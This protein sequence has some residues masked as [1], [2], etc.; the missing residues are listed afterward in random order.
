MCCINIFLSLT[1]NKHRTLIIYEGTHLIHEK[2]FEDMDISEPKDWNII[3]E[4]YCASLIDRMKFLE[5][6]AGALVIW[7]SRTF[8]QN[9]TE[10]VPKKT[11]EITKMIDLFRDVSG[12]LLL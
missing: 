7:D 4:V 8:H 6:P 3:D 5:V 1:K 11:S 2:Y 12:V 10:M 9:I